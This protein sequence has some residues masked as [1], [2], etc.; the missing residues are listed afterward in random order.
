M[1]FQFLLLFKHLNEKIFYREQTSRA[2]DLDA[3]SILRQDKLDL[4]ARFMEIESV[5][6]R[7][8]QKK[9]AEELSYSTFTLQHY[10]N[11]I[12]MQNP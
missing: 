12:K 10:R 8:K 1:V 6:L 2:G 9:I 11:D 7:M 4:M 5:N 3:N